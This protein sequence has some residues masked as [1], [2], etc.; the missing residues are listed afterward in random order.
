MQSSGFWRALWRRALW[1]TCTYIVLLI[2]GFTGIIIWSALT[3]HAP[4]S[5]DGATGILP[6]LTRLSPPELELV[7]ACLL[8]AQQQAAKQPA[9]RPP[10]GV[11]P[12]AASSVPGGR[13]ASR[14]G[15]RRQQQEDPGHAA[16]GNHHH[17]ASP[18]SRAWHELQ[19]II[20]ALERGL[21]CTQQRTGSGPAAAPAAPGEGGGAGD[22]GFAARQGLVEGEWGPGPEVG[23][24]TVRRVRSR[25]LLRLLLGMAET[26]TGE[27]GGGSSGDGDDGDDSGDNEVV[28]EAEGAP[29]PGDSQEGAGSHV[30]TKDPRAGGTATGAGVAPAAVAATALEAWV[31]ATQGGGAPA[32]APAAGKPSGARTDAQAKQGPSERHH[33]E[34]SK[35]E[36]AAPA[37]GKQAPSKEQREAA[38][39][40]A[41]GS[42]ARG[43][44]SRLHFPDRFKDVRAD[45]PLGWPEMHPTFLGTLYGGTPRWFGEASEQAGF[46]QAHTR[47]PVHGA[48]LITSTCR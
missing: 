28:P 19:D 1:A 20:Q 32:T 3:V 44:S 14:G 43:P 47:C 35:R 40:G 13:H 48:V 8:L 33:H 7:K 42:D 18:T 23:D 29:Q 37:G 41:G 25:H 34:P 11:L 45:E 22:V 17:D 31:R 30:V 16:D 9:R 38:A 15:L 12:G 6:A 2:L 27:R 26:A 24:V 36:G 4:G 5:A 10:G 21:S 46:P 39:A